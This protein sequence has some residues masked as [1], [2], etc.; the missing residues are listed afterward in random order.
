M[1]R[2]PTL[3]VVDIGNTNI[4][5]GVFEGEELTHSWRV[6]TRKAQTTDEYAVLCQNLFQLSNLSA[7]AVEA[8]V[9]CSV[10]PP[11]NECFAS[12]ARQYFRAEPLFVEPEKQEL[13][14]IL[15]HPET[16]VGADRIVN[17]IAAFRLYGG[18]GIIVDFGTATT[19]DA[20][21][22]NGNYGGGIIAPGIGVSSEALFLR[23]AKLPRIEIRQPDEVIGRS[24][25]SSM[26]AGVFYGYVGLVEGILKRMKEELGSATVTATG[27]FAE[28]IATGFSGFD[29]IEPNLTMHGLRICYQEIWSN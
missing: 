11:L 19:F 25:A 16:D 23:A 8:V 7:L 10:V 24:T 29:R 18:P 4:V 15:Y 3:L 21:S 26:Q 1:A 12:L 20:V 27:G 13:M 9:L 28:L 6:S 14:P 17:A 5:L 22:A 2:N